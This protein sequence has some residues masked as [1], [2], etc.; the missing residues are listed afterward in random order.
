MDERAFGAALAG[1]RRFLI[2]FARK[3]FGMAPND[4]EDFAQETMLKAW[5]ARERYTEQENFRA[6]L[7]T[8]LSNAVFSQKRKGGRRGQVIFTDDETIIANAGSVSGGQFESVY[9]GQISEAMGNI[10]PDQLEALLLIALGHEY[11]EVAKITS[12]MC[13]TAKSRIGRGR[14]ALRRILGEEP[15]R[16]QILVAAE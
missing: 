11:E 6:W 7:L 14:Q 16:R 2:N 15:S 1:E 8:I 12:V 4:A 3:K 5:A 13:G 9:L 10:P